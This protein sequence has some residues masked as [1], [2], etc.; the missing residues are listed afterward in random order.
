M[1]NVTFL[2]SNLIDIIK[3]LPKRSII[4]KSSLHSIPLHRLLPCPLQ[5]PHPHLIGHPPQSRTWSWV[6]HTSHSIPFLKQ[7]PL[8]ILLYRAPS[9]ILSFFQHDP[10]IIV[11]VFGAQ[12]VVVWIEL[13]AGGSAN[14]TEENECS[15]CSLR[16]KG[17]AVA[18][19]I[20]EGGPD[21][22]CMKA[23]RNTQDS[24]RRASATNGC[25]CSIGSKSNV[26]QSWSEVYW[27]LLGWP[28]L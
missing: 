22:H 21:A 6:T 13:T 18:R 2:N 17:L 5:N 15:V 10:R 14:S 27:K 4:P 20:K 7:T 12:A 26:Y 19:C 28:L 23:S 11:V 3:L 25:G 16:K 24:V 1:N 9:A 8:R